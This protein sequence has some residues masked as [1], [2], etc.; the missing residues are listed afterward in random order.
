MIETDDDDLVEA[1]VLTTEEK[2]EFA[3]AR[4]TRLEDRLERVAVAVQQ[5]LP[6]VNFGEA[7]YA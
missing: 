3:L 5:A 4:I 7:L 2:L 6:H 1:A